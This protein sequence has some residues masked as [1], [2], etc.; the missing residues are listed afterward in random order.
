MRAYEEACP[1]ISSSRSR[2]GLSLKVS[3][4]FL[5]YLFIFSRIRQVKTQSL[6]E[7]GKCAEQVSLEQI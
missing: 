7:G 2:F 4:E 3:K 1:L 5:T 6:G